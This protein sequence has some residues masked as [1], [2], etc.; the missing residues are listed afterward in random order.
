MVMRKKQ[1][2]DE[3]F[4]MQLDE[5]DCLYFLYYTQFNVQKIQ[6]NIPDLTSILQQKS[7]K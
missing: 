5:Q 4:L 2:Y 6:H 7:F 3:L 1:L